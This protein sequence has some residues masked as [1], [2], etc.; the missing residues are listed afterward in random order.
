[1][2]DVVAQLATIGSQFDSIAPQF[3]AIMT[4]F[5]RPG[6]RGAGGHQQRAGN[7]DN[8]FHHYLTRQALAGRRRSIRFDGVQ[9]G[10]LARQFPAGLSAVSM[11]R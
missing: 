3:A 5:S 9:Y 7:K 1:V 10:R 6:R 2:T 4:D 8:S 11:T